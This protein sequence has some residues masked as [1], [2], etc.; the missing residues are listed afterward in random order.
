[1]KVFIT[2]ATGFLGINLIHLLVKQGVEITAIKR[3]DAK[4]AA[5]DGMAI[6]WQQA[7]LLDRQSLIDA[8]PAN[9][10]VIF[11]LAGDANMWSK[12]NTQQ[13]RVN[14]QGTANI[15]DV[16]IAK[17]AKRLVHTSSVSV[18]GSHKQVIS[19]LTRQSGNLC[20]VNYY[21]N[22]H[23]AEKLV[24]AAVAEQGLDAVIL[25]P[26][27]IIGPWDYQNWSQLFDLVDNNKLPIIPCG[28]GNFCHVREVAKAH[29]AAATQGRRG[30]NYILGGVEVSFVEIIGQIAQMLGKQSSNTVAPYWLLKLV[31]IISVFVARFT[32]KPPDMTPEKAFIMSDV[33]KVDCQKAQ[34]ELG[35]RADISLAEMLTDCYQWKK[36]EAAA[37]CFGG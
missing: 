30:E 3:T 16:A 22:K 35:Y 31:G 28:V 37:S 6:D 36:Q 32:H 7:D 25:N 18:Y 33:L 20:H 12:H 19:E 2:G 14:V 10:D 21:Q 4:M 26:C 8:C 9:V 5:F 34:R 23:Q 1:M 15:I 27:Y 17:Q 13:T 11:H 29:I 24:K